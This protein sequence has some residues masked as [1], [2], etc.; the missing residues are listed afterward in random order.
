MIVDKLV[1]T[2]TSSSIGGSEA[3]MVALLMVCASN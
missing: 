1:H 3:E 2:N